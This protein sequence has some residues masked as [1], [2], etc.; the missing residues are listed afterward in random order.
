MCLWS[1]GSISIK[2]IS[3]SQFS[4]R[5]S[6][7]INKHSFYLTLGLLQLILTLGEKFNRR[8]V[9]RK[10]RNQQQDMMLAVPLLSSSK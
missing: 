3:Q 6:G 1:L 9:G 7:K 10:W 2:G 5:F 8:G 4:K